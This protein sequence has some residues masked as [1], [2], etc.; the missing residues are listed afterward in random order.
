MIISLRDH[1]AESRGERIRK[2]GQYLEKLLA[3]SRAS[4]SL[5]HRVDVAYQEE[6]LGG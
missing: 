1:P 4:C 3:L 6:T 2:I 5:T